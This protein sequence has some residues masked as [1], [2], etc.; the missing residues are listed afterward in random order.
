MKIIEQFGKEDLATV[1]LGKTERGHIE[2]VESVEPPLSRDEKWVLILSSLY[3]CPIECEMCDAGGEYRGKL[4]KEEIFAQIDHMVLNRYPDRNIPSKKFKIQFARVGEPSFNKNVLTTLRELPKRYN[5]H[6][7]LPAISTVAPNT[8][9]DF[10][11]ELLE[12]KSDLYRERFQLQFSLH[13]TNERERDRIIPTDKWN[14]EEIARYGERFFSDG[15]RKI[16]L[17]FIL[18]KNYTIDADVIKQ[19]FSPE[20]FF[21]KMTPLNPTCR[22]TLSG[23]KSALD[24]ESNCDKL[25][26]VESLR[27]YGFDLLLS[28]GELE[29][30]LIGSNCGQY[31]KTFQDLN[32]GLKNSYRLTNYMR[33]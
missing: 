4:T 29:E 18:A 3:G 12:I 16:T 25:P 17:N 22:T 20:K 28:I 26:I 24:D 5:A 32:V 23:I 8:A 11:E 31:I 30:N 21:I 6:G 10:F 14:L 9:D 2:F 19:Y 13:S 33:S 7:L 15:D 1:Y 27:N